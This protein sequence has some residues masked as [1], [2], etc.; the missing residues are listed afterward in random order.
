MVQEGRKLKTIGN[1]GK[2]Q[3]GAISQQGRGGA[4]AGTLHP[5]LGASTKIKADSTFY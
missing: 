2:P 4:D 1:K 3:T 5:S